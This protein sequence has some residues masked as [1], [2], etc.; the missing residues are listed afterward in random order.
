MIS[1][2]NL[3]KSLEVKLR[4]VTTLAWKESM[5][6]E[7]SIQNGEIYKLWEK[8]SLGGQ[9]LVDSQRGSLQKSS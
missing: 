3:L 4:S 7:K 5:V 9:G 6:K 2:P 8:P 1:G